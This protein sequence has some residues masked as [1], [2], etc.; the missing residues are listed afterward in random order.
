MASKTRGTPREGDLFLQ[1]I[2]CCA[3]CGHKMFVRYK[4]G[5]EYVCNHLRTQQGLPACQSI[6]AAAIDAAVGRAFLTAVA[7]AEVDALSRASRLRKE[8]D[9]AA[10][11][12]AHQQVERKRYQAALAQRQYDKVDPDNRLVAAELERRWE[13]ALIELRKAE[14]VAATSDVPSVSDPGFDR[15]LQDKVVLLAGRLPALWDDPDTRERPP[16]GT[17]AVPRREGRSRARIA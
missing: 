9:T 6:R 4:C 3:R 8:V 11:A 15:A 5:S 1:G 2:A 10:R 7:P 14:E 17:P 12:A 13:A 16:Q